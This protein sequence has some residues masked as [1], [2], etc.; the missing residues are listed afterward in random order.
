M[1]VRLG[2]SDAPQR[3]RHG[4]HRGKVA[5]GATLLALLALLLPVSS[6]SAGRLVE[7][8]EVADVACAVNSDPGACHFLRVAVDYVRTGAP[9]PNAPILVFDEAPNHMYNAIVR[10]YGGSP[11]SLVEANPSQIDFV[12]T[13]ITPAQFSAIAIASDFSCGPF[14]TLFPPNPPFSPPASPPACGDLNSPAFWPFGGTTTPQHPWYRNDPNQSNAGTNPE[15][16]ADLSQLT[17]DS[18]ALVAPPGHNAINNFYD[19]GGGLLVGSG[20][21]NGD[22]HAGD[23]YYD[24]VNAP[25]GSLFNGDG[26]ALTSAGQAIGFSSSDIGHHGLTCPAAPSGSPTF[27]LECPYDS[28]FPLPTGSS[29][30]VAEVDNLGDP[31]TLFQDTD[32]PRTTIT[33]APAPMVVSRGPA[34]AT[35]TFA[36]SENLVA[37]Q[38]RLDSGAFTPCSSPATYSSLG[39]GDHVFSVRAIDAAGNVE[40][41]PPAVSWLLAFDRDGDGYTRFSNPP[42]CN[43]NNP[44]IHPGAFEPPGG[45]IDVDCDGIL[46]PFPVIHP[47]VSFFVRAAR[48]STQFTNLVVSAVPAGATVDISCASRGRCPFRHT[49][50]KAKRGNSRVSFTG[51]LRGRQLPVGLTLAIRITHPLQIGGYVA[52]VMRRSNLPRAQ[53]RCMNPGQRSPQTVCPRYT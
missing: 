53:T 8:G 44:L 22:G 11:P 45:H 23:L 3:E 49:S 51:L 12:H 5:L 15:V 18:D 28:F 27:Y 16:P 52:L 50:V 17:P 33:S 24:F 39:E 4:R 21:D 31:V 26:S 7:T 32:P 19:A 14:P 10:A 36:A 48:R 6:A 29:L 37:F 43:D 25:R 47:N 30:R 2:D 35:F 40:A 42:D 9:N 34:S 20:G 46:D 41:A 38:C 1:G 13:S